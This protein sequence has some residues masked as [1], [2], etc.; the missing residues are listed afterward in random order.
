M[1]L[2]HVV[3][4]AHMTHINGFSIPTAAPKYALL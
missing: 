2:T 4:D 1:L 3:D